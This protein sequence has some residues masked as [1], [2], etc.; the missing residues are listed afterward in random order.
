MKDHRKQLVRAVNGLIPPVR[1]AARGEWHPNLVE[2]A[3][4]RALRDI[5]KDVK[6]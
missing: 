4:L 6:A 1:A 2:R 3:L 5:V